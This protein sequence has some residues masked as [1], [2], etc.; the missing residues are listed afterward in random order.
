MRPDTQFFTV[1]QIGTL[2][3]R[4]KIWTSLWDANRAQEA[5]RFTLS[6]DP[7]PLDEQKYVLPNRG[8]DL[9]GA[10]KDM[11]RQREIQQP[12]FFF[13]SLPL[14]DPAQGN[15]ENEFWF[16]DCIGESGS[17]RAIISTYWWEHSFP[18]HHVKKYVLMILSSYMLWQKMNLMPHDDEI[19][20]RCINDYNDDV[21]SMLACLDGD[22]LC[23]DCWQKLDSQIEQGLFSVFEAAAALRLLY[24]AGGR[25]SCFVAMP[26][27]EAML[28]VYDVIKSTLSQSGWFV[29]RADEMHCLR[30][31]TDA[32]LFGICIADR[33]I[34]DV[35]DKNANVAYELGVAKGLSKDTFLLTQDKEL[36]FDLKDKRASLYGT[37]SGQPNL[38]KLESDLKAAFDLPRNE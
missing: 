2:N 13:T 28:P 4:N 9:I 25:R 38:Q 16:D 24:K 10:L 32:I 33:V 14:G 3:N 21:V 31:I 35:T 5:F 1:Y 34:A 22:G 26:F 6:P 20:R 8:Y 18:G 12:A 29:L 23:P 11:C 19:A 30:N 17:L 36:P 37:A 27:D 7:L 15:D